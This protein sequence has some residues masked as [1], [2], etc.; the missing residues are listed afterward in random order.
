[1]NW[2]EV[3]FENIERIEAFRRQNIFSLL[4]HDVL[5]QPGILGFE[6]VINNRVINQPRQLLVVRGRIGHCWVV[7]WSVLLLSRKRER[8]A[9]LDA[10]HF[11]NVFLEPLVPA[12]LLN[13]L[14][15]LFLSMQQFVDILS[16]IGLEL[17]VVS[18]LLRDRFLKGHQ[19]FFIG[20]VVKDSLLHPFVENSIVSSASRL[21]Q[22]RFQKLELLVELVDFVLLFKQ[23]LVKSLFLLVLLQFFD[24]RTLFLLFQILKLILIGWTNS[25]L[26]DF[27][28]LIKIFSS[29]SG[30]LLDLPQF[31]GH[32][33]VP[34]AL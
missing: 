4:R 29:D 2:T 1:M 23:E 9:D 18:L 19:I 34:L 14:D 32:N 22:S 3:T 26:L 21:E 5:E 27:K 12:M 11:V 8:L 7:H 16:E 20:I 6:L 30:L 24:F 31:L 13:I 25:L 17:S 33:D 28:Q 10:I 15:Y